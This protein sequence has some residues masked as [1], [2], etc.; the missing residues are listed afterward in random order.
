ME[1]VPHQRNR[2]NKEPEP[3]KP[4]RKLLYLEINQLLVPCVSCQRKFA[5]DRIENHQSVCRLSREVPRIPYNSYQHRVQ[6]TD[7]EYFTLLGR[8]QERKYR[9]AEDAA[10][11]NWRKRHEEFIQNLRK[12]RQIKT[13][14][15]RDD[16][17]F[18]QPPPQPVYIELFDIASV[19]QQQNPHCRM[20][21]QRRCHNNNA[22][23][24]PLPSAEYRELYNRYS[25]ESSQYHSN[26]SSQQESEFSDAEPATPKSG[27]ADYRK[28]NKQMK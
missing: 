18:D 24:L 3:S 4:Q 26:R 16:E 2:H 1:L 7:L 21:Q 6:G 15:A 5:E 10:N 22:R 23:R 27:T 8:P 28:Y 14:L 20:T 12:M 19:P 9:A 11:L 17:L 13:Y 25:G